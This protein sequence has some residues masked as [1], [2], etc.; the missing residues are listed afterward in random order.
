MEQERPGSAGPSLS[1]RRSTAFG[2]R[3]ASKMLRNGV[4]G[5]ELG[6]KFRSARARWMKPLTWPSRPRLGT[7]AGNTKL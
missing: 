1:F 2:V 7:P 6:E 4:T 3:P 5:A